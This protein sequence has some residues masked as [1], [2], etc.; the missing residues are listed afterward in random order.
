MDLDLGELNSALRAFTRRSAG[1]DVSLVFYAGHGLEVDRVN[2]LLPV[3]ARLERDTDVRFET[4]TLED[5]LA[6]TAGA[7][8]R[9]VILDACRNNPLASSMQ[10]T[11]ARR[12]ISRGSFGDLDES[13]LGDETLVAY[14]AAVG[15]TAADGRGSRNSPYTAALLAHLEQPLELTS[16]FRGV[17]RQVLR[18]TGSQRPWE[19]GSLLGDHYLAGTGPPPSEE[20]VFWESIRESSNPA[21]FEAYL[22][23]YPTGAYAPLAR[24][25][26]RSPNVPEP[27]VPV[28]PGTTLRDCPTCPEL[29]VVPAGTFRM[30][31]QDAAVRDSGTTPVHSVEIR[32][33]A[34]GRREVTLSDYREFAES[35]GYP[36]RACSRRVDGVAAACVSWNDARSYMQWLQQETGQRYRLLSEAEWE[37]VALQAS[38]YG[39]KEMTQ[40]GAREWVEDCWH[41]SYEGAPS[42]GSAWL[43]N[44]LCRLRVRRGGMASP[45]TRAFGPV[46]SPDG[47]FRVARILESPR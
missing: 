19:Y 5:V 39:V 26:L 22:S 18:A 41:D 38:G 27:P 14:A 37:Y 35:T 42:D 3:D 33:F 43:S 13:L 10:R 21:D 32:S 17:R 6:A 4:V 34:V 46:L 9:L 12:S 1:A 23:L 2:Y 45:R 30:G 7:A 25:R 44:G 15:T 8:L 36:A 20:T 29:V 47:S 16:V 24:N 31:S 28:E 11:D 40:G